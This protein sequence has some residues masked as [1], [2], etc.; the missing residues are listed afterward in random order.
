MAS[1][2]EQLGLAHAA[3]VEVALWREV[4][5]SAAPDPADEM[6]MRAMAEAQ[7]LFVMGTGHALANLAVRALAH[8]RTLREELCRKLRRGRSR[9]TFDPFSQNRADWVSLNAE[10][11]NAV[12]A[13]AQA[14]GAKGAVRLVEP[15]V[16]FGTGQAWKAL[17]E[18]RGEDFHRWRPQSH[19]VE[20][21]PQTSPWQRGDR[22]RSLSIS[23][24]L[25]DE[26]QGLAD[27]TARV[28]SEAMLELA[29]SMAAFMQAWPSAAVCLGGPK[30]KLAQDGESRARSS[31]ARTGEADPD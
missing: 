14:S 30:F 17:Q 3:A 24:P 7:C 20:G 29:R 19:G 23:H 18:R 31:D 2:G 13:V 26:T 8:D 4:R 22:S 27:E 25:Y 21:V 15:V 9:P 16:D 10:T 12:R 6:C 11:C 28:A 1:A 5:E